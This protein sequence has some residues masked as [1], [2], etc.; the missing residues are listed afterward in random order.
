MTTHTQ[1]QDMIDA[2]YLI[3]DMVID[4]CKQDDLIGYKQIIHDGVRPTNIHLHDAVI[5]RAWKIIGHIVEDCEIGVDNVVLYEALANGSIDIAEYLMDYRTTKVGPGHLYLAIV[6]QSHAILEKMVAIGSHAKD[7]YATQ[8]AE[9]NDATNPGVIRCYVTVG[10]WIDGLFPS[11]YATEISMK[12]HADNERLVAY[13][14][15]RDARPQRVIDFSDIMM[16]C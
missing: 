12:M 9:L 10:G 5:Y 1:I 8:V 3:E 13:I 11:D 2:Q 6:S 4:C 14:S 15:R 7:L 16:R